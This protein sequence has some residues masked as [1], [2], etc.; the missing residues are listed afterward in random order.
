M[1]LNHDS[2]QQ[3]QEKPCVIRWVD[4]NKVC[5]ICGKVREGN[6][7]LCVVCEVCDVEKE[8]AIEKK[9]EK[10]STSP[11]ELT[12]HST[13]TTH[14]VEELA[15][16]RKN[17]LYCSQIIQKQQTS[18]AN[19]REA[20]AIAK[21]PV[22]SQSDLFQCFHC[23][24]CFSSDTERLKHR[25]IAHPDKLDYPEPEDF[26]YRLRPNR[27]VTKAISSVEVKEPGIPSQKK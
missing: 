6:S 26:N 5:E 21:G 17:I 4:I 23:N 14:S 22:L 19:Q 24:E 1:L 12:T 27:T 20:T 8:P 11:Q 3:V 25:G 18:A 13:H 15:T 7:N 9:E 2:V 16:I 10:E